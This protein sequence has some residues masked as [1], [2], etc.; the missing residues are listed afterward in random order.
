ML[1]DWIRITV[2]M[3]WTIACFCTIARAG[4]KPVA[5]PSTRP[6]ALLPLYGGYAMLQVLDVAST[7]R[8]IDRGAAEANGA[9]AG[10]TPHPAA[11]LA[12]K[13]VAT[14]GTILLAERIWPHS[15]V[16]AVVMMAAVDSAYVAAVAHNYQVARSGP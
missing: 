16:A 5:A 14:A 1:R 10:I 3:I 15:R 6:A 9:M 11:L 12:V 8:A 4:G 7:W 2:L 13:A